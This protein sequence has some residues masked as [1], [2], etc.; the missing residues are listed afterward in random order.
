MYDGL[1]VDDCLFVQCMKY[2]CAHISSLVIY[3][4]A[5]KSAHIFY[6]MKKSC[7]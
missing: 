7:E 6:V 3:L 4:R 1:I 5:H 2:I